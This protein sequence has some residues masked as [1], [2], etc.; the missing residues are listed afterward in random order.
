[1]N[2]S[3]FF[4]HQMWSCKALCIVELESSPTFKNHCQCCVLLTHSRERKY[5]AKLVAMMKKNHCSGGFII[6]F[7]NK[8]GFY[9]LGCIHANFQM[10]WSLSIFKT[11]PLS[12]I[13]LNV[14]MGEI[15]NDIMLWLKA[16]ILKP[17]LSWSFELIYLLQP[18]SRQI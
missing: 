1:M 5:A 16:S 13:V 14:S 4:T 11:A 15:K 10:A 2:N 7:A 6:D 12:R 3:E 18:F 17:V 8:S 9:S